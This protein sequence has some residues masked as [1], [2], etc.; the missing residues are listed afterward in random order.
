MS[1]VWNVT[2]TEY[3]TALQ[4][5]RETSTSP[6]DSGAYWQLCRFYRGQIFHRDE[7]ARAVR[8]LRAMASKAD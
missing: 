2:A 1:N 6:E 8:L 4:L 3:K 5:S 7:A